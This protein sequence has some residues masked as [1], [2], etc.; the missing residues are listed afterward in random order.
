MHLHAS[1]RDAM[2]CPLVVCGA[3]QCLTMDCCGAGRLVEAGFDA[4]A[5]M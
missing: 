5:A 1:L 3:P 4:A 2:P